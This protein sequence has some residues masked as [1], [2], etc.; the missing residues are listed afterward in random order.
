MKCLAELK[1]VKEMGGVEL[2]YS[3][4]GLLAPPALCSMLR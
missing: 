1:E 4:L 3:T 2:R